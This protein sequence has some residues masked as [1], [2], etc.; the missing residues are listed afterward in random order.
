MSFDFT[1]SMYQL[2]N[3]INATI[4]LFVLIGCLIWL[5][6]FAKSAIM[7]KDRI[8]G[9]LVVTALLLSFNSAYKIIAQLGQGFGLS[10]YRLLFVFM[11]TLVGLISFGLVLWMFY[12][13]RETNG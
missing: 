6:R 10:E 3:F 1:L 8:G 5:G 13:G 12:L 7:H 2:L 11:S 4:T 9:F